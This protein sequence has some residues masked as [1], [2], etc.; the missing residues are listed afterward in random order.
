MMPL[1]PILLTT[2]LA[3]NPASDRITAADLAP[4]FPGMEAAPPDTPLALAPAPGVARVFHILELERVAAH[5]GLE[6]PRA[7]ICVQRK[8]APPDPG[9]MLLAMQK[10]L[11]DARIEILDLGR[12]PVPE[13]ELEFSRAGLHEGPAGS[14]WNGNVRYAGSRLFPI[15]AKVTVWARAQRVVAAANLQPGQA[16][17]EGLLRVELR[18]EF[19]AAADFPD[20]IA[21]VIG[22]TPRSLIRAGC[23]IRTDQLETPKEVRM[24]ETVRVDV[25]NGAAHLKLDARAENSGSVGQIIA[26]R[27]PDSQ[28]RFLAR[29]EGKGKVSVDGSGAERNQ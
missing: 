7:E 25:W 22:K 19:P 23:S 9:Q 1:I 11:P 15:W 2:C 13:G 21:Q 16:I 18:H 29:V 10:V 8:V 28:K 5:F 24:G 27:N 4:Q 3:A 20:S 26:V 14:F 6:A 17:T 12:R